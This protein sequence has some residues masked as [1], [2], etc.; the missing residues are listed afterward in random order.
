MGRVVLETAVVD[1]DTDDDDKDDEVALERGQEGPEPEDDELADNEMALAAGADRAEPEDDGAEDAVEGSD[2][3]G[4][5]DGIDGSEEDGE[6][7][8]GAE[9]E[10]ELPEKIGVDALFF[11]AFLSFL[12]RFL[13]L[14]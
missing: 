3:D 5:D 9:E 7:E 10:L 11:C 2:E 13:Y 6:V 8:D 1:A 14:L 4:A 12:F